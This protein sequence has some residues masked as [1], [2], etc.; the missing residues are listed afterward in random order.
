MALAA[1]T[2]ETWGIAG[3]TFLPAYLVIAATVGAGSICARR[4]LAEPG[5]TRPLADL[6]DHPHDVAY[7]A[8]GGE[9][10]VWSALCAMHLRGTLT[11]AGGAVH[12]AGR[13]DAAADALEK[14]IHATADTPVGR[15]RLMFHRWV[16]PALATI[17]ER[18]VAGGF[19]LSDD[20]RRRIRW[21][22]F[23]M[24]GVAVLGLVRVLAEIAQARSVGPLVTALLAV[25]AVG[26]VQVTIAPRR[27][28]RGNRALAALR[29][30]HRALAPERAPDWQ[31]H[32]PADAALGIGLFGTKALA[33][34][35][36]G[37]ARE[38]APQVAAASGNG[39]ARL[40]V[41]GGGGG[42]RGGGDRG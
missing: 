41:S 35:A 7:L 12:A 22:G 33:A 26:V 1:A 28:R 11:A 37:F 39:S 9:L 13:L 5:A 17:D 18:L 3:S 34:A 23:L 27:T 19:L 21:V 25:T 36:P 31:S 30:R 32:G 40:A 15:Q 20:H 4:A 38:V 42:G 8:G 6:T 2:A 24:L 16:R 14:A 10:A 29:D